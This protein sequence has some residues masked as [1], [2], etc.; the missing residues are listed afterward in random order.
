MIVYYESQPTGKAEL[1]VANVVSIE[2]SGGVA[3]A[4]AGL[5]VDFQFD[6][7]GNLLTTHGS[8]PGHVPGGNLVTL[9]FPLVRHP[10]G[11]TV[12]LGTKGFGI[13]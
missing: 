1:L 7:V 8:F 13:R 6:C 11:Q 3:A 9:R 12:G 2:V 4:I 5:E 10:G